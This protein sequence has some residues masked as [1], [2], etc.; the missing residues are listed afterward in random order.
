[1]LKPT[2]SQTSSTRGSSAVVTPQVITTN[3][4]GERFGVTI[5]GNGSGG[6]KEKKMRPAK[7]TYTLNPGVIATG[8]ATEQPFPPIG[9]EWT[10]L[11]LSAAYIKAAGLADFGGSVEVRRHTLGWTYQQVAAAANIQPSALSKLIRAHG[12][13][14]LLSLAKV[15]AGLGCHLHI[16]LIPVATPAFGRS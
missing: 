13:P 12:N 14:E 2:N 6:R 11:Q 10:E 16:E 8:A 5:T 4:T 3:S 1:M 15:A 7:I 9:Q